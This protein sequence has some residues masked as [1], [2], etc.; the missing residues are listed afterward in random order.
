[1]SA[2]DGVE[3]DEEGRDVWVELDVMGEEDGVR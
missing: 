1:M 2:W 3:G